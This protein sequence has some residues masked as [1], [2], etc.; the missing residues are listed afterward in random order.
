M[1]KEGEAKRPEKQDSLY[2]QNSS[3]IIMIT[4]C[5]YHLPTSAEL[6][7]Q[8]SE[9]GALDLGG[10]RQVWGRCRVGSRRGL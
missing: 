3:F 9:V 5:F 6:F 7:R 1:Y 4:K 8:G 2:T 10:L